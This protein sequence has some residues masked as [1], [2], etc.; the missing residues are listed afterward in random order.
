MKVTT[1]IEG[2]PYVADVLTNRL[3]AKVNQRAVVAALKFAAVPMRRAAKANAQALGGS[4]ALAMSLGIWQRRRGQK[5][6]A[7]FGSV[8][9][10]PRRGN[11][12]ALAAYYNFYKGRTPTPKQLQAGIR[13]GHLV[14]FGTK[15]TAPRRFMQ[16]AFDAKARESV[17]RFYEVLATAVERE[18]AKAGREQPR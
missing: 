8:E 14:E 13:H 1:T 6:G 2:L 10:G 3:P 11:K 4:G 15:R 18:A 9:V 7:T 5:T 16:R 12:R 17:D